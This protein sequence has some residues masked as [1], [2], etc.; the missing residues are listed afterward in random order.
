LIKLTDAQVR[1]LCRIYYFSN[2]I[3]PQRRGLKETFVHKTST[4]NLVSKG[5]VHRSSKGIINPTG[6]G[7]HLL[8]NSY[9]SELVHYILSTWGDSVPSAV[10]QIIHKLPKRVL[11]EYLAH[12]DRRV[13]VYA[14]RCRE[15]T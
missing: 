1:A 9:H 7:E 14:R 2:Y 12:K 6:E 11:P 4:R 8:L 3:F 13:R 5:L 10:E 15:W